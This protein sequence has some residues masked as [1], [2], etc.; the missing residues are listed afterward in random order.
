MGFVM[1][2]LRRALDE[3]VETDPAA[4]GDAAAML[5]LHRELARME[6]VVTRAAAAFDGSKEWQ[7]DGAQTAAQWLAT[8][9]RLPRG[10]AR[11]RVS[12]GRK[13]RLLPVCEEAWTA[14]QI[15]G[16]HV[17]TIGAVMRPRTAAALARDEA[18]L[19]DHATNLRFE[20][21]A[22]MVAYWDQR[23]D[24]D[25]DDEREQARL[26]RRDV[27][28]VESFSGMFL[29]RMTMDPV[30]G[31]I[32]HDEL[33]RREQ[34]LFE[35]DWAEARARLGHDPT[36]GELRRTAAQR[37]CDALVEMA[38]RSL[39]FGAG[40]RRPAPLFSVLVGYETMH[41]RICQLAGGT[42]VSPGGLLPWLEEAYLE[43]AV[44]RPPARVEVSE[45]ARLF[46]GATRRGLELRDQF[47]RHPYCDRPWPDC[48]ADHVIPWSKGG[49]TT[50]DN[51]ELLC[52]FHNRLKQK[53][54]PPDDE[55]DGV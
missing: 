44:F 54:P 26:A 29:G 24:P 1:E 55:D 39:G 38:T 48:Q 11:K 18:L 52:G 47:C 46:K 17:S 16:W 49:P 50:Q 9:C 35:A 4:L 53:R 10:V 51:G 7:A 33:A 3:L 40:D 8:R 42:I 23:A 21:F 5:E 13:L 27:Y 14:G 25:G 12:V 41:G 31:A 19:V 6:A 34:E 32:V 2:A 30:S 43:R 28:L 22:R 45:T 36:A 37:R 20:A 15:T